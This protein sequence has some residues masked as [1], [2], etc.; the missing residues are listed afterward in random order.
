MA[1]RY[2][3]V[4]EKRDGEWRIASRTVAYDWVDRQTPPEESEAERFGPLQPIGGFY[5]EDPIYK[6]RGLG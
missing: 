4:F 6:L 1:G 3:D 5:P 2:C